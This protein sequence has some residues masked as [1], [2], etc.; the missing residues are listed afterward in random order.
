LIGNRNS[1][2][3]GGFDDDSPNDLGVYEWK[4][5]AILAHDGHFTNFASTL[6]RFYD[7][8]ISYILAFIESI[9]ARRFWSSKLALMT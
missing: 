5:Q 2:T 1:E 4:L 6:Y 8:L 9:A 7:T 3:G